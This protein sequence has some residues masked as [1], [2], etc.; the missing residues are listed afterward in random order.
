MNKKQKIVLVAFGTKDLKRSKRRLY[1]QAQNSKF[2]DDIKIFDYHFFDR[3][4]KTMIKRLIK[5]KKERGYGY[6]IWKPYFI[7][8]VFKE[9]KYGDIINYIVNM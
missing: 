1:L 9:I 6:W 5:N 4:M 3:D 2:Y 7:L 8:K